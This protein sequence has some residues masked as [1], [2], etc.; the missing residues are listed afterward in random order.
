MVRQKVLDARASGTCTKCF[1]RPAEEGKAYCNHCLK[2]DKKRYNKSKKRVLSQA[3]K[4]AIAEGRRNAFAKKDKGE[5]RT[6]TKRIGV[7]PMQMQ[8]MI[9]ELEMFISKLSKMTASEYLEGR[10][11][12]IKNIL[13]R[14]K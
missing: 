14:G 13:L 5:K 1:K 6:Y 10:E 8:G 4:D 2:Y 9:N 11:N 7:S 3:H 12:L